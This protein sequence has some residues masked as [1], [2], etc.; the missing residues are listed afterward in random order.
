M[1]IRAIPRL[2]TAVGIGALLAW[3][4]A[5]GEDFKL[6][7]QFSPDSL[8]GQSAQHF[9]EL[10]AEKT[11]R[12]SL[13]TVLPGGALG[14]ERANLQQLTN[15]SIDM[16]LTGDL[17]ISSMA[18]P[19]MLVSMP[20]IYDSPAHSLAVFNG[21]I[22]SEIDQYLLK[23]HGI[24]ALGWQY[25]GTRELTSNTP[26][27]NLDE[28]KGLKVRLPGAQMWVKTWEKTGIDIVSVAFTE[29]YLALQT[30]TVAAEENPPNFVRA[31]KFYEVQ[32]YLMK[33]DHVPQMQVFFINQD[34]FAGLD[35]ATRKA[36][37]EAAKET[38]AWTSKKASDLQLSDIE[39]LTTEGGM[40]LVDVDLAGIQD[41][42]KDVPSE[43]L[44]EDGVKL[45]ERIRAA[46]P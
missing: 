22:G 24:H 14:D 41:L 30:G 25:V 28:L 26:V 43:V 3:S 35:E 7:H 34:R 46:K 45:Y 12:D 19:Y 9:A 4:P 39:W 15:G 2:V 8:P 27:H 5:L 16:A 36:V 20:F 42:I 18:Q 17:V 29:L 11:Q 31:Q 44:G 33:T 10:V 38:I 13:V 23:N 1:R 37:D 32:K 21:E 6:A 40:E